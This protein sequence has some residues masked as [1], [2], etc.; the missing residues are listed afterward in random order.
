MFCE[1]SFL[2]QLVRESLEMFNS[3]KEDKMCTEL[4]EIRVFVPSST[5]LYGVD[6]YDDVPKFGSLGG[7]DIGILQPKG[8]KDH[9]VVMSY[10]MPCLMY[11]VANNS[12]TPKILLLET[13]G[14]REFRI[15]PEDMSPPSLERCACGPFRVSANINK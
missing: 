9:M 8:L 12:L 6:E 11:K 5:T 1:E 7:I 15:D 14:Q 4:E 10:L 13:T 2:G 3:L